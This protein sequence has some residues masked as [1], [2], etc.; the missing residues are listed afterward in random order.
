MIL[1][2]GRV[3]KG[4]L[5][6]TMAS[7]V[8]LAGCAKQ[9]E[10]NKG[11]TASPSPTAAPSTQTSPTAAPVIEF[12]W[13]NYPAVM[14]DNSYAQKLIESKFN[15]KLKKM[16]AI[17]NSDYFQKQ[18]IQLATG[19]IPDVLFVN[20]PGDLNKYVAQGLL[21]EI[22]VSLI[23]KYAPRTKA[24]MDKQAPQ[25]WYYTSVSGKNYGVPTFYFTGQFH[26]KQLW[27]TDLLK[28]AGVTKIP[29]TIDE[30]TAAFAALKQI[31]V[32]GMSGTGNSFYNAFHSIFGAYGLMPTQWMLKDGKVVNAAVQPEAKEALAK[33]AEWF[34]AGYIDPDFVSGKDVSAKFASGKTAFNDSA[35][36][37]S[38]DPDD[39][40]S[41]MNSVKKIDPN[42]TVEFGPLPKGPRGQSGGWAWGTA[43]NIW[44]FGKQLEKSPEKMQRALQI[45]DSLQNDEETWLAMAWG[46]Q[47]KHWD[48]KD[49]AKGVA[50]GLKRLEPYTDVTKL[51]AEGI[52]DLQNGV[53]LFGAQANIDLTGKYYDQKQLAS[54]KIFNKSISDIFGKSDIL[55]SS[56]KYWGDLTKLKTETYA[57]IIIGDIPISG[58]DN[59]V[60][61]WNEK[62]GAQ[63]EKEANEFYSS[64]KK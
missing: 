15:V 49:P 35:H 33:L 39:P 56:G 7:V 23:E 51:Q 10:E 5:C 34:K 3:G 58:F 41:T 12:N 36:V 43:G 20:N 6:F 8:A 59:F 1:T 25:G 26:T 40:G 37:A 57:Q 47:G 22:P 31:G 27:R 52:V 19:D 53:T 9:G 2:R 18:Q 54:F 4:L 48:F 44:A 46:Q 16:Y 45:M 13:M 63:L 29:E 11:A 61:Q 32:Y 21:A 60:K 28:K 64:I 62:G 42:G 17:P 14:Q 50:G 38:T 24:N 55:P 30:F